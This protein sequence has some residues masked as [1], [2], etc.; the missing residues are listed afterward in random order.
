MLGPKKKSKY[1]FDVSMGANN[2][3]EICELGG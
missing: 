1:Q 3:A 2:G